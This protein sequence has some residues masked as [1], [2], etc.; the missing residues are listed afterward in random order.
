VPSSSLDAEWGDDDLDWGASSSA[1]FEMSLAPKIR[2]S[3]PPPEPTPVRSVEAAPA[4]VPEAIKAEPTEAPSARTS[5]RWRGRKK[6]KGDAEPTATP[7]ASETTAAAPAAPATE[8]VAS[9][10]AAKPGRKRKRR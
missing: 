2:G 9:E 6:K 4:A 1:T 8:A 3:I 5:Q 7:A 10:A